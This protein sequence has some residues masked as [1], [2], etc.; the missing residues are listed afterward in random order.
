MCA[1]LQLVSA[2]GSFCFAARILCFLDRSTSSE[3]QKETARSLILSGIEIHASI[4]DYFGG[5]AWFG[6]VINICF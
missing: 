1:I 6:A 5:L 2:P 4:T 3:G